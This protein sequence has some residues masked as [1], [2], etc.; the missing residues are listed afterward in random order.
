MQYAYQ[1][2]FF[3]DQNSFAT[4]RFW[5]LLAFLPFFC[6]TSSPRAELFPWR[7]SFHLEKQ[8]AKKVAWGRDWVNGEGGRWGPAVFSQKLLNTQLVWEGVLT[9]HPS[10][11]WQTYWKNHQ[12][13]NSLKPLTA[14]H[15][16]SQQG[17]VV[18]WDRWVPK[19]LTLQGEPVLQG[20]LPL[21]DNSVL[22][23][24]SYYIPCLFCAVLC[25]KK[26]I[27]SAYSQ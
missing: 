13:K 26:D 15:S 1:D 3:S 10:W 5:S 7:T 8:T 9:N 20:V 14:S 11:N 17:Q 22:G 2:I 18:S 23:G 21:E 6:F 16:L 27:V 4:H 24:P 25:S 12:K 19:R